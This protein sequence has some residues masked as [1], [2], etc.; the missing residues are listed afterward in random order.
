MMILFWFAAAAPIIGAAVSAMGG[1]LTGK[2]Q[3]RFSAR[4][5]STA[6]Q[7]EVQ[8]LRLAGL[9]PIL[10]ATGGAGA[11]TPTPNI[12]H[13]GKEFAE[14]AR[15]SSALALEKKAVDARAH[16][17]ESSA[18]SIDQQKIGR[19]ADNE[20]A[21]AEAHFWRRLNQL[22]EGLPDAPRLM[23]LLKSYMPKRGSAAKPLKDS[24]DKAKEYWKGSNKKSMDRIR[25]GQDRIIR[26]DRFLK[27][28][29]RTWKVGEKI[30]EGTKVNPILGPDGVVTG[31]KEIL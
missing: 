23:D 14:A 4:M 24:L 12:P 26:K 8:D 13:V 27:R 25:K 31:Y 9:N 16:L 10:S 2:N 5:S 7:R 3:Q 15:A 1:Y 30:P 29:P 20:R 6:H 18:K 22:A 28:K 17:D 21:K 19:E 11:S